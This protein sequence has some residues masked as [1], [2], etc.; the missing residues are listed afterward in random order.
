M[1][2]TTA[3]ASPGPDEP[4]LYSSGSSD[5]GFPPPFTAAPHESRRRKPPRPRRVV[6]VAASGTALLALL[7][8]IALSPGQEGGERLEATLSSS[9]RDRLDE[10]TSGIYRAA[11]G[12]AE[13]DAATATWRG[14]EDALTRL[15]ADGSDSPGEENDDPVAPLPPR[16]EWS[17]EDWKLRSY[18]WKT[19]PV[20]RSLERMLAGLT[21]VRFSFLLL[22]RS[23]GQIVVPADSGLSN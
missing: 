8:L 20:H 11:F 6:V 9:Y 17:T 14:D 22:A 4:L 3:G 18:T 16:R 13:S 5:F 23:R 10:W 12:K 1:P 7:L 15:D 21:P 19:P 2:A